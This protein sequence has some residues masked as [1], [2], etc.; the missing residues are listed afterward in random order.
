MNN[1]MSKEILTAEER[2]IINSINPE[3][4]KENLFYNTWNNTYL[5]LYIYSEVEHDKAQYDMERGF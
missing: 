4:V 2:N 3:W 1:L 5:N